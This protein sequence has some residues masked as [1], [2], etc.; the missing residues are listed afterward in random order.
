MAITATIQVFVLICANAWVYQSQGGRRG[1]PALCDITNCSLSSQAL[2]GK[3]SGGQEWQCGGERCRPK[4][5]NPHSLN[6]STRNAEERRGRRTR[7]RRQRKQQRGAVEPQQLLAQPSTSSRGV[8][9]LQCVSVW[10]LFVEGKCDCGWFHR[11]AV[12][13]LFIVTKPPMKLMRLQ[14]DHHWCSDGMETATR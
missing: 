8:S 10:G 14:Q 9:S 4:R 6:P 7:T 3:A 11:R 2:K 5:H 1:I 13:L 12:Q